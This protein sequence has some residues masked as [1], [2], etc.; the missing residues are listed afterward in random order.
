VQQRER[1]RVEARTR[2]RHE[3]VGA[4]LVGQEYGAVVQN[5]GQH[6][7]GDGKERETGERRGGGKEK[8]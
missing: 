7:R 4:R 6:C 1:E 3:R 2:Q 5:S 8:R